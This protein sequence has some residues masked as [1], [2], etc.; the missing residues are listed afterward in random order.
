M[1]A[2][3]R[4]DGPADAHSNSFR[5]ARR[6]CSKTAVEIHREEQRNRVRTAW[7]SASP[8]RPVAAPHK[9]TPSDPCTSNPANCAITRASA[10][11]VSSQSAFRSRVSVI[12]SASPVP[13]SRT[14]CWTTGSLRCP[15]L[16][17]RTR[18]QRGPRRGHPGISFL[19]SS[20]TAPG[21]ATS[22]VPA[23]TFSA[24]AS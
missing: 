10:S 20:C 3:K 13:S 4:G 1:D 16:S 5:S 8:S 7:A 2:G 17:R 14:S 11:S 9:I 6:A 22:A 19:S 23:S 12:A 15:D 18:S 24:P 21:M